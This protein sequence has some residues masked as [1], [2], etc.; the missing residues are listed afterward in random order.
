MALETIF[1][2]L[3][4][5]K[6]N[7]PDTIPI[8]GTAI[9]MDDGKLCKM[10]TSIFDAA[11]S[12]CNI[13]VMFVS[14]GKTQNNEFRNELIKLLK[15]QT[16][17]A[18]TPLADRLQQA[19]DGKS[20]MGLLFIC[21]GKDGQ[22][23]RVVISRFPADEGIV[24]QRKSEQLNVEFVEQVF[25]KSS[26]SYKSA[27]YQTT[28][29]SDDLWKGHATDK[30]INHGAKIVADYWIVDFLKSDFATTPAQGTKRLVVALKN[31]L[32]ATT[33]PEIKK[34]IVAAAQLAP[35]I[36]SKAMTI[37]E[38]CDD[39]NFSQKTK[40]AVAAAVNPPRLLMEKFQFSSAEFESH[41]AYKQVDLDN[42]ATLTALA[43]KFDQC[44][45]A[46]QDKGSILFS[47]RGVVTDQRL[48]TRK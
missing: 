35:N 24:A 20:G 1:S 17:L 36:S 40:T 39:F 30:Q 21:I 32:S 46:K 14:D 31:V 6:K 19:T 9:A 27:T 18:A 29:K 8:S 45:H 12:D 26:H 13:P 10:L 16:I 33:D 42:G 28:G 4:Y 48:R 15:T 7:K 3:T 2:F 44:F 25:L 47:T 11:G 43:T 41:L 23:T 37:A 22:S 34:E 38:F 5:P